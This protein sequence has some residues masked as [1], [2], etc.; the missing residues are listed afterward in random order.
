[1]DWVIQK[2]FFVLAILTALGFIGMGWLVSD[3]RKKVKKI[4]QYN[5]I[6][7]ILDRFTSDETFSVIIS[8]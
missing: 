4:S 5:C 7:K 2:Q 1:M 3:T 6:S 8:L